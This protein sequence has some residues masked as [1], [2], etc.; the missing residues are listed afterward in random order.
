MTLMLAAFWTQS[1]FMAVGSF[2]KDQG[3]KPGVLSSGT[4]SN[5]KFSPDNSR[6]AVAFEGVPYLQIFNTSTWAKLTFPTGVL[7]AASYI[8]YSPGGDLLACGQGYGSQPYLR[9]LNTSSWAQVSIADGIT[10]TISAV[11][12]SPDG[13]MLAVAHSAAPFLTVYDVATWTKKTLSGGGPAGALRGIS[14]SPDSSMLATICDVSTPRLVV[15]RTSDFVKLSGIPQPTSNGRAV[16]FSADGTQLAVAYFVSPYISAY[17]VS[18]WSSIPIP[19]G[20]LPGVPTAFGTSPGGNLLAVAHAGAPYATIYDMAT[21]AKIP[22]PSYIDLPQPPSAIALNNQ[23]PLV[24]RGGV[25]DANNN[26]AARTV[27]VLERSSGRICA[28]TTSDPVTGDYSAKV[29]EGDVDYDVQF[30]AAPGE[31]LNDLFFA[32]VRAG[33]P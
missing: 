14:F 25:R 24:I 12:F 3:F 19:S 16:A 13:T 4:Y 31:L 1:P 10:S 23:T 32:R 21:W 9:V 15:Y 30:M 26:V 11:E 18:D 22:L 17:K 20:A 27:R 2:S 8:S 5:A 28:I 6:L 33:A 7:N 29:Y